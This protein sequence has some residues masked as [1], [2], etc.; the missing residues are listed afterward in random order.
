MKRRG[1][2]KAGVVVLAVLATAAA[3]WGYWTTQ[4]SGSATASVGT[5]SAPSASASTSAGS[6]TVSVTWSASTL[7]NGTAATGYYVTRTNTATAQTSAACSS[8]PSALVSST[9]CSDS[10]VPDGAYTYKVVAVY[11]SWTAASAAS[12]QVTVQSDATAPSI[13]VSFPAEGSLYKASAWNA[14]CSPSAGICGTASDSS[15]VASVEVSILRQSSGKYWDGTGFNDSTE[16]FRTATGTTSWRY[17]LALPPDGAYTVHVRATD[18]VGNATASGAYVTRHFT[19]DATAPTPTVTPNAAASNTQPLTYA[20]TFDEPVSDLTAANVTVSAPAANTGLAKSV[21]KTDSQ[22]FTVSVSG[23]KTDGT[24]DGAVSVQVNAGAVTDAA[25]NGSAASGVAATTWDRTVPTRTA[26][27]FFDSNGNGKVDQ[28]KATYNENLGNY[29]VGNSP[30]ALTNVPSGGSLSS[31]S[32]S[33]AV[34]TL[35][36]TEGAGAPDTTVGSFRVTYTAPGSGGIADAAG[37]NAATFSSATPTDKAAPALTALQMLDTDT[38]GK[39]NRVTAAFSENL[40]SSSATTPWTLTNVPSGGSLSSV[41]TSGTTATL[42]IAEGAGAADTSVGSFTVALAASSTG[43]RDSGGNQSSFAA[44]A[45]ADKAGPVPV[46]VTDSDSSTAGNGKFEQ[47]D[48]M[49]VT[50]S[51]NVTGVAASSTVVLTDKGGSS[52]NDGVSMT[53]FVSGTANLGSGNYISGSS[54]TFASSPLSQPALNQVRLTLAA[55][56]SGS[57]ANVTQATAN[58]GFTYTPV[59]SITDAAANPAAGSVTISIRLF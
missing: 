52:N 48:S 37:N 45:P 38:D 8:S 12:N 28:V 58:A 35:T 14:G 3:A 23:L 56:S 47:N 11:H 36:L 18:G 43:I 44:Q 30:W 10:S 9:S 41:S 32:V 13:T 46:D 40:A 26:L 1:T 57:C 50:F 31:V 20:V 21:S 7:S 54:A 53:N 39:V 24:G 33:G 55:C 59:T 25:G 51:E 34:V 49:T 19:V 42:T 16:N 5:L 29:T 4:G 17:A 6:S 2:I 22:H 15:G 27:E